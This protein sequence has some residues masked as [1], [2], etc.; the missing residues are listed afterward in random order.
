LPGEFIRTELHTNANHQPLS[1]PVLLEPHNF[2]QPEVQTLIEL[3]LVDHE[4][5]SSEELNFAVVSRDNVLPV[6]TAQGAGRDNS[7]RTLRE[8]LHTD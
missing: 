2:W 1:V 4:D 3:S 6:P 8:R 5:T 7:F